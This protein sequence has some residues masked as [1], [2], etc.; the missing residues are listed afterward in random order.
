METRKCSNC[1]GEFLPNETTCPR[2][3]PPSRSMHRGHP[4]RVIG[5]VCTALAAQLRIDVAVLRVAFVVGALA[6]FGMV[7]WFY[8]LLWLVTPPMP[9]GRPPARRLL[10]WLSSLF[11]AAPP[12]VT[13]TT[14]P[15]GAIDRNDRF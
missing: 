12:P 10:D 1:Q 3:A 9:E 14:P 6:S 5:G 8:G 4:G 15:A 13:H 7:V 2:C 11:S